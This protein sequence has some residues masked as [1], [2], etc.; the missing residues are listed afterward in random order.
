MAVLLT[1]GYFAEIALSEQPVAGESFIA[2]LQ[3]D[4]TAAIAAG[5][6]FLL[7]LALRTRLPLVPL[8]FAY[9][10]LA[11]TGSSQL[12]GVLALLAGL[13][14]AAYSAGDSATS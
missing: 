1:V 13:V 4:E 14:L 3:V 10:A 5:G 2:T 9:V 7:S 11:L 6:V 12:D 8:A